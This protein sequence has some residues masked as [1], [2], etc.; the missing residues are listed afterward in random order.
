M[1]QAGIEDSL[2][3]ST[4]TITATADTSSIDDSSSDAATQSSLSNTCTDESSLCASGFLPSV[5]ENGVCH[6][7]NFM[8]AYGPGV[9]VLRYQ[10]S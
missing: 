9:R 8:Q 5:P 7:Y 10:D 3:C 1:A 6:V 2:L 4:V